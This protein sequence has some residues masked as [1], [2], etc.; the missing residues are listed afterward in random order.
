[1]SP[2]TTIIISQRIW[3]LVTASP[4]LEMR[5]LLESATTVVSQTNPRSIAQF[6]GHLA[7]SFFKT[8]GEAAQRID[9]LPLQDKQEIK[10]GL[11]GL[12]SRTGK[13]RASIRMLMKEDDELSRILS[14]RGWWVLPKDI[15]GPVKRELI[16]PER[17]G[18]ASGIDL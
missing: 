15:N 7:R 4:K 10:E 16:R 11:I 1:L 6:I 12:L 5:V 14:A 9:Q 2:N 18:E 17:D 13:N 8:L 3:E